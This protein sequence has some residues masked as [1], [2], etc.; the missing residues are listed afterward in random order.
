MKKAFVTTIA[1][2]IL[3]VSIYSQDMF[4]VR[5]LTTDPAQ[6]GFPTWSPDGKSIVYQ[7]SARKDPDGKTQQAL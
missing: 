1:L 2:C 7:R 3:T 4:K 5:Q 6:Q